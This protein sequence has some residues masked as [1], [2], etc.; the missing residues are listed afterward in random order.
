MSQFT[1]RKAK[2]PHPGPW[3]GVVTNYLDPARMGSLEV[4]LA[5]S[6]MGSLVLQNETVIVRQMTPF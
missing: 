4:V 6:T 2:L 1:R 5:K 3:L